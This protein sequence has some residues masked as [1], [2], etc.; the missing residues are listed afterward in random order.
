[1]GKGED[2]RKGEKRQGKERQKGEGRRE[3]RCSPNEKFTTTPL[4]IL[5]T[6]VLLQIIEYL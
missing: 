3:G 4:V 1:M 6:F 5:Y 2:G